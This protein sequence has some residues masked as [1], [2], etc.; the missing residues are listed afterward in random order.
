VRLAGLTFET[1][2]RSTCSVSTTRR[3]WRAGAIVASGDAIFKTLGDEVFQALGLLVHLVRG[4]LQ[5]IVKEQF[6]QPVMA[7]EF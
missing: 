2:L 5:N 3:L 7:D 1:R 4:V 6:E